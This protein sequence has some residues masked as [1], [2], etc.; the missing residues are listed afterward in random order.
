MSIHLF[1]RNK[2]NLPHKMML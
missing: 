1:D 2:S